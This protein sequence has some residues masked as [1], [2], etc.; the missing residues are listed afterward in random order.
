MKKV[1][2]LLFLPILINAQSETSI[3]STEW[4]TDYDKA[5]EQA[6]NDDKNILVYFTG[7]DW[8]PPCK[9]LKKDFFDTEE[10]KTLSVEYIMLYIDLPRDRTII[11]SDQRLH[12]QKL[13]GKLNKRG[14]FPFI[15][16]LDGKE[17]ILDELSGYN[18][19]GNTKKHLKLI[20]KH[21]N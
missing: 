20:E 21:K 15:A 12:N 13:L 18:M 16:I 10:F 1:L 2:L 3:K 19:D 17:R 7:S 8:C 6:Q 4:L 5:L 9:M 11:S 14:V